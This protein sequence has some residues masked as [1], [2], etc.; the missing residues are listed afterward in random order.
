MVHSFQLFIIFLP[1]LLQR[2]VILGGRCYDI[3]SPF[4]VKCC[5]LNSARALKT[6]LRLFFFSFVFS[7]SRIWIQSSE[8]HTLN[9]HGYVL[10]TQYPIPQP[11]LNRSFSW[12]HGCFL[13]LIRYGQPKR[14]GLKILH[15]SSWDWRKCPYL[16]QNSLEMCYDPNLQ[17]ERSSCGLLWWALKLAS[18]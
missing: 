3:V 9:C 18:M 16:E 7:Q 6:E 1:S 13:H 14:G 5:I 17:M 4:R 10:L 15:S 8:K 12:K 11:I 2:S